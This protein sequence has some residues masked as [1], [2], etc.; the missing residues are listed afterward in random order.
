MTRRGILWVLAALSV[1]ACV[2]LIEAPPSRAQEVTTLEE[3]L[4]TAL[5]LN[6]N[7]ESSSAAADLLRVQQACGSPGPLEQEGL[8]M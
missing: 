8:R 2:A 4:R 1:Q 7:I 3:A 6:P 5:S